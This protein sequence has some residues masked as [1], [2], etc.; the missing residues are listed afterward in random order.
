MDNNAE[1]NM[2]VGNVE[3]MAKATKDLGAVC[4]DLYNSPGGFIIC[5]SNRKTGRGLHI[6]VSS[7]GE[8]VL[9]RLRQREF[10]RQVVRYMG[11]V[12]I[13]DYIRK[14]A[15]TL[16]DMGFRVELCIEQNIQTSYELQKELQEG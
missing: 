12:E 9:C 8:I 15:E 2:I 13:V 16:R 4:I 6:D 1:R 7:T 5:Y 11:L 14:G 3:L 10:L